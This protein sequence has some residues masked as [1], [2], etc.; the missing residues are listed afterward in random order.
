M[1]EN[2]VFRC[3]PKR[4]AVMHTLFGVLA[5][6]VFYS[7]LFAVRR[8]IGT[9]QWNS[10]VQYGF[11]IFLL[12]YAVMSVIVTLSSKKRELKVTATEIVYNYGLF[13]ARKVAL[14]FSRILACETR[15]SRT[16]Q[17]FNTSD[18]LIYTIGDIKALYLDDIKEGEKAYR[19]VLELIQ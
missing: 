14:P 12:I 2:K 8:Q 11:W 7:I 16:Q 5:I 15:K 13:S 19:T 10:Y 3:T 18:L 4:I 1:E 17:L 6:V 9:G